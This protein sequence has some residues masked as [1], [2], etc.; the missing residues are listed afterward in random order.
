[1]GRCP[2]AGDVTGRDSALRNCR[3]SLQALPRRRTPPRRCRGRGVCARCERCAEGPI[4]SPSEPD[5]L[6][7]APCRL[8]P[9]S[10]TSTRTASCTGTSSERWGGRGAPRAA[11]PSHHPRPLLGRAAPPSLHPPALPTSLQACK[12]HA[13]RTGARRRAA[14]R[15]LRLLAGAGR[16]GGGVRR[17]RGSARRGCRCRCQ[18]ECGRAAGHIA[19]H[20]ARALCA[21]RP[22]RAPR[23]ALVPLGRVRVGRARVAGGGSMT[24]GEDYPWSGASDSPHALLL[25]PAPCSS[26]RPRRCPTRLC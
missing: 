18:Y 2:G 12:H 25:P 21:A 6:L 7:V 24:G 3:R 5:S 14:A 26:S 17:G 20:G 4:R 13:G 19:I 23:P 9:A 1:M 11:C 15:R 10:H 22:R 16:G 8:R